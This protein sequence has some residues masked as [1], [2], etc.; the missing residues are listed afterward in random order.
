MITTITVAKKAIAEAKKAS[1]KLF[2]GEITVGKKECWLVGI[3]LLL[4]GIAIGLINAPLTHGINV[5]LFSHNGCNNGNNSPVGKDAD[6]LC[7]LGGGNKED[8]KED[9]GEEINNCGNSCKRR[10]KK[11]WISCQR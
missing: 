7:K 6:K 5:S 8:I 9:A 10:K 2:I 4:T 1:E 11:K 3:I